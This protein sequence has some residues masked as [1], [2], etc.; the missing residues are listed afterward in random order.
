MAP[1]CLPKHL[2][3]QKIFQ[4]PSARQC[5]WQSEREADATPTAGVG[6]MVSA[7]A[8]AVRR[9][10]HIAKTTREFIFMVAAVDYSQLI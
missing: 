10:R 5:S 7:N 9:S 6:E 4:W 8:G 2:I 3:W 1:E